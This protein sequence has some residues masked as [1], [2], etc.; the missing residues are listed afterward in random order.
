MLSGH[1]PFYDNDPIGIYR[2]ILNGVIEFPTFFSLRAK[3]IIRKLLNPNVEKR[4]GFQD[5]SVIKEHKWFRGV[6]WE[7]ILNKDIPPPWIP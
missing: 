1:P 5:P 3:D 7:D 2:K 4:L 6:V